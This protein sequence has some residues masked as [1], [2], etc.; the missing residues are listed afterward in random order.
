MKIDSDFCNR[1]VEIYS[2]RFSENEL[3][4]EYRSVD[5]HIATVAMEVFKIA[6]EELQKQKD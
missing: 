2:K 4:N 3:N 6:F 5:V 1:V